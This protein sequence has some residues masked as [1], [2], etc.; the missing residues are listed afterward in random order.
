[1]ASLKLNGTQQ[2]VS[3]G[4][5]AKQAVNQNGGHIGEA[6]N[7]ARQGGGDEERATHHNVV[8]GV[9]QDKIEEGTFDHPVNRLDGLPAEI[10]HLTQHFRPFHKVVHRSVQ[11]T[12]NGYSDLLDQLSELT[13]A[14]SLTGSNASYVKPQINGAASGD[15]SPENMEKKDRILKFQQDQRALY[16]KFL[17]LHDWFQKSRGIDQVIEISIWMHEQ[18]THFA[19]AADFIGNMKRELAMWQVPNPDLQTAVEILSNGRVSALS[20]LGYVPKKPLS[21]K[22]MLRTL[23]DINILLCT[24]LSLQDGIPGPLSKYSIHDGRVTFIVPHEFELDLSVADEDPTSQFYFIDFRYLFAQRSTFLSG[25]LHDDFASKINDVLRGEGLLGCYNLLHDLALSHKLNS[26]RRQ[27]LDMVRKQWCESLRVNLINRTLVVQYWLNRPRPKSWIE[28]GVKSG[29]R[30]NRR[31]RL[32]SAEPFLDLRWIPEKEENHEI[33]VDFDASPLSIENMLCGAISRHSSIILE[34]LYEKLLSFGLYAGGKHALELSISHAEPTDCS[35]RIQL[36]NSKHVTLSIEPI[37]GSLILRPA[38]SLSG[39]TEFE[40]NRLQNPVDDGVQHI[41]MLRCLVAE[42][43]FTQQANIAGWQI[44]P[45]FR[46]SQRELRALFPPAVLRYV[47]IRQHSWQQNAMVAATF[48]ME[49]DNWWLLYPGGQGS[50]R[51]PKALVPQR[52]PRVEWQEESKTNSTA[53]LSQLKEYASGAIAFKIAEQELKQKGL[54]CQSFALPQLQKHVP[55]PLMRVRYALTDEERTMRSL[56]SDA[57]S[58]DEVQDDKK[59]ENP[60]W[61]QPT[62]CLGFCGLNKST[63]SALLLAKGR[64]NASTDVLEGLSSLVGSNFKINTK[65]CEFLMSFQVPIGISVVPELFTGLRNLDSLLS[66]LT[67]VKSFKAARIQSLSLSQIVIEYNPEA[68][69]VTSIDFPSSNSSVAIRLLPEGFNPH[70][71]ISH[72]IENLLADR[73]R[74]FTAN[75]G[76]VLTMLS[77]TYPL[78]TLF[79]E[80]EKLRTASDSAIESEA[81]SPSTVRLHAIARS[82]THYALQYFASSTY[83]STMIARV[84]IFRHLRRDSPVWILR[85]AIEETLAYSRSSFINTALKQKLMDDVFNI[86]G[87]HGW[88]GLDTGASCP[89]DSPG[90]LV[91][92]IDEVVRTWAK[93]RLKELLGESHRHE[94]QSS[95]DETRASASKSA[96]VPNHSADP[97]SRHPQNQQHHQ[98]HQQPQRPGTEA[99]N[100][101]IN[102]TIQGR[103][104]ANT[105]KPASQRQHGAKDIINLD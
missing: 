32:R 4:I 95:K 88:L 53:L 9:A 81:S 51:D 30:K 98:Q 26:L 99:S 48:S 93:E 10:G 45:T 78:L 33:L 16:I 7:G 21:S 59:D 29:R 58:K 100:P 83:S 86:R 3:N 56:M 1:M 46:L 6:L 20:D 74:R 69:L 70:T 12:F 36:T 49:S 75:L 38:S 41:S 23:E 61:I 63:N 101:T 27:A 50:A 39:R 62:V 65:A 97:T 54:H 96:P 102:G 14:P 15:Q 104:A 71:R 11:Q 25:R 18:R 89:I 77:T 92:K 72:F 90:P 55:L 66:C 82:P 17:V 103:P 40:L 67:I 35:L 44:L 52:I 57:E 28:L 47:L 94:K 8:N 37:T 64:T 68:E 73:K 85:P 76:G 13:V 84:E 43:E 24:R 31:D 80:L 91:R 87:A 60:S 105:Q 34:R 2:P 19:Q 22:G 42:Q 5:I 79:D